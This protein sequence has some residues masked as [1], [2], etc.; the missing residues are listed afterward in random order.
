MPTQAEKK[1]SEVPTYT[2]P[3]TTYTEKVEIRYKEGGTY[4]TPKNTA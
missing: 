3:L 4:I 1:E 2:E